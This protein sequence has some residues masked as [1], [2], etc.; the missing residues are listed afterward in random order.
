[1]FHKTLSEYRF[2]KEDCSMELVTL[3]VNVHGVL[4]WT[5]ADIRDQGRKPRTHL[6]MHD[7]LYRN[8]YRG[9]K[10]VGEEN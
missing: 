1:M 7:Q 8:T 9:G 2:L 4:G 6:A 5:V 10:K 3:S